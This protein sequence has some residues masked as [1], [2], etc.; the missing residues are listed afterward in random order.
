MQRYHKLHIKMSKNTASKDVGDWFKKCELVHEK[1]IIGND[2]VGYIDNP[3]VE[4]FAL[5]EAKKNKVELQNKFPKRWIVINGE[6]ITITK[7]NFKDYDVKDMVR[8]IPAEFLPDP[9]EV[10]I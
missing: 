7:D 6:L 4:D 8:E 1:G 2:Y 10:L 5:E 9:D 3:D